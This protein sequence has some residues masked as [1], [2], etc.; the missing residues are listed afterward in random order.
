MK[1]LLKRK[2]SRYVLLLLISIFLIWNIVWGINYY[3]YYKYSDGYEKSP[4]NYFKSIKDYTYTVDCPSYLRLTG[5]FAVTN[6]DDL[7]ILI[8]PSLFANSAEYGVS[9]D[10]KKRNATYRFYVDKDLNYLRHE[11][12]DYSEPDEEYI[13]SLLYKNSKELSEMQQLAVKEWAQF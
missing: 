12:M 4:I 5:N 13:K 7:S 3:S 8:W 1:K 6:N 10:D 2:K 11:D 9:I